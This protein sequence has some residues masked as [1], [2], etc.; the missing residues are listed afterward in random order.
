M[1]SVW[2]FCLP[3]IRNLLSGRDIPYIL[4]FPAYGKGPF[5]RLGIPTTVP[6]LTAFLT[7]CILEAIAGWLLWHGH[8]SGAILAV[9]LIPAGAIF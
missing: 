9:T 7:V 3:A 5:E 6:L 4:G 8:K 2:R 1:P